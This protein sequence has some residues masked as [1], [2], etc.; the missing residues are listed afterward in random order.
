MLLVLA[1]ATAVLVGLGMTATTFATIRVC[2]QQL[3][4]QQELPGRR[5]AA[6]VFWVTI[7]PMFVFG[8]VVVVGGVLLVWLG[9]T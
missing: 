2:R 1:G 5:M 7:V 6:F 9:A 3:A 4:E 8:L